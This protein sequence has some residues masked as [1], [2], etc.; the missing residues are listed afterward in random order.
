MNRISGLLAVTVLAGCS[1]I[2]TNDQ[3]LAELQ[4]AAEVIGDSYVDC[5]VGAGT[6]MVSS[7]NV[8]VATAVT[9]AADQCKTQLDSY[10]NAQEKYLGSRSM[11]TAKPLQQSIDALNEEATRKIGS[12]LLASGQPLVMPADPAVAAAAA[13]AVAA[14]AASQAPA[15][16]PATSAS[17]GWDADQRIYLDCMEDQA[18]KY[19]TL[20]E[21]AP[22]IADVAHSRC[23]SYMGGMNAALE[24]EGRAQVMGAVMDARLGATKPRG[25]ARPQ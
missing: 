19:A 15:S 24:D 7:S 16:Q 3:E 5:V 13:G 25:Q 10:T 22:T 4:S 9:L 11:M 12:K 6:P 21:S 17:A 23:K 1:Q 18:V 14:T 20:N 8:D 2:T